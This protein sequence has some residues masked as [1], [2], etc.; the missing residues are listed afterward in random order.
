MHPI[1]CP[2]AHHKD[3]AGGLKR[4]GKKGKSQLCAPRG[5]VPDID[6]GGDQCARRWEMCVVVND[7]AGGSFASLPAWPGEALM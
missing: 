1:C 7:P 5:D 6:G 2:N 3:S 4:R